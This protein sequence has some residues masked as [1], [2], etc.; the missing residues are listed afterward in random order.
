M[1]P[2]AGQDFAQTSANEWIDLTREGE[3]VLF[4]T[5]RQ[6]NRLLT[7]DGKPGDESTIRYCV[8]AK[9]RFYAELLARLRVAKHRQTQCS[10]YNSRGRWIETYS[11]TG[12]RRRRPF[13]MLLAKL[14]KYASLTLGFCTAI[15]IFSAISPNAFGGER[16]RWTQL[17]TTMKFGLLVAG[18]LCAVVSVAAANAFRRMLLWLATRPAKAPWG[19]SRREYFYRQLAAQ[20]PAFL[21]PA[22]ISLQPSDIAWPS[23][24]KYQSWSN[25]LVRNGFHRFGSFKSPET[26]LQ[27][28]FWLGDSNQL[29]AEMV[30]RRDG[31]MWLSVTTYYGEIECFCVVNK[32][33][34]IIEPRP[35]NKTV[36]IGYQATA[37]D[38]IK[39]A[40]QEKPPIQPVRQDPKNLIDEY[41]KRWK[42]N[43]LWHRS[44]G[45]AAE[46]IKSIVDRRRARK[47]QVS[48]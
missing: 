44:H 48:Q 15:L 34:S 45:A 37:D 42:E 41:Q 23:L 26:H 28:E 30:N 47:Q 2:A 43:V 21:V 22:E 10:L 31:E 27:V 46:Q 25:A 13:V 9:N 5:D 8:A 40:R 6:T 35:E 11:E 4:F 12:V 16:I 36:Y 18:T 1:L 14:S 29:C 32:D 19:S 33:P 39:T 24:E 38:V 20:S 3:V 7:A 17:S